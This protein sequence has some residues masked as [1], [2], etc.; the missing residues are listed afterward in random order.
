MVI[1]LF[2]IARGRK[3]VDDAIVRDDI[4]AEDRVGF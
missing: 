4:A 3:E 1:L 2:S